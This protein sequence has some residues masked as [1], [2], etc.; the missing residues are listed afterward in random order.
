MAVK[1]LWCIAFAGLVLAVHPIAVAYIGLEINNQAMTTY[2]W[3][4]I[5]FIPVGSLVFLC[6]SVAAITVQLSQ[7][8]R[9][10]SSNSE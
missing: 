6:S 5:V 2:H 3:L 7:R 4:A 10:K 8:S 1:I 9:R